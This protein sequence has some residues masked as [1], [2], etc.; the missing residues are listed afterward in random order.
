MILLAV[1]FI[2]NNILLLLFVGEFDKLFSCRQT[3]CVVN[4]CDVVTVI[5]ESEQSL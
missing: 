5:I 3:N 4:V 2:E 1:P